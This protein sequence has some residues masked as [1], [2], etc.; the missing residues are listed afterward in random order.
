MSC[1]VSPEGLTQVLAALTA[2]GLVSLTSA[3][4]SLEELFIDAYRMPA[5]V[6]A[7]SPTS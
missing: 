2:A 1:S 4:P 7:E 5:K 3:P 6:V